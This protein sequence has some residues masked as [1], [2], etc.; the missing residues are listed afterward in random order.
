MIRTEQFADVNGTQNTARNFLNVMIEL[1]ESDDVGTPLHLKLV[2][3][4]EN[5]IRDGLDMPLDWSDTKTVLLPRQHLLKKLDPSGVLNVPQL[6]ERGGPS[7]AST[8][9]FSSRI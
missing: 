5:S 9:T 2:I 3:Y 4:H 1:E 7:S 8:S 6:R